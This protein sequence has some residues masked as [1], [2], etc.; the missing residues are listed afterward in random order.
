MSIEGAFLKNSKKVDKAESEI[1]ARSFG[2]SGLYPKDVLDE[3]QTPED[4]IEKY[5]KLVIPLRLRFENYFYQ[6]KEKLEQ[7]REPEI[8]KLFDDLEDEITEQ[9]DGI[10]NDRTSADQLNKEIFN[11]E[12]RIKQ[13]ENLSEELL[14]KQEEAETLKQ[15]Y[16]QIVLDKALAICSHPDLNFNLSEKAIVLGHILERYHKYTAIEH[17]IGM[18]K[19]ID[20]LLN[21]SFNNKKLDYTLDVNTIKDRLAGDLK[22][23]SDMSSIDAL[24]SD[25]KEDPVVRY[26]ELQAPLM[27][28]LNAESVQDLIMKMNLGAWLHNIGK[29][30]IPLSLIDGDE[31][32]ASQ[33]DQIALHIKEGERIL[34]EFGFP[35]EIR[36]MAL[37]HHPSRQNYREILKSIPRVG[38]DIKIPIQTKLIEIADIYNALTTP[39]SY[40]PEVHSRLSALQIT[41]RAIGNDSEYKELFKLFV[42]YIVN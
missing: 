4:V 25:I 24:L 1:V 17:C 30:C 15:D 13:G 35:E 31:I 38:E 41:K 5:D 32:S 11:L 28:S 6:D 14:K 29:I 2:L 27:R 12:K 3:I 42:K 34:K 36:D 33:R 37:F 22:D 21:E 23:P 8:Q 26:K 10:E 18:C 19:D 9:N 40:R 20:K 39:R 7:I 16:A